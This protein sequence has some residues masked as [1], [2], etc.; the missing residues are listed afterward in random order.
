MSS[1][2][3]QQADL[4]QTET[5]LRES[6][7]GNPPSLRQLRGR[8]GDPLAALVSEAAELQWRARQK[9]ASATHSDPQSL[10]WTT[11]R[12]LAQATPAR[13]ADLKARLLS[14]ER[15]WDLCCGI[16][17]DSL[18]L[19]RN[20]ST[21]NVGEVYSVDR[22]PVLMAMLKENVRL[23]QPVAETRWEAICDD[24]LSQDYQP[25]DGVH[26]DPDRRIDGKR[27]TRPQ[28]Y[29]PAWAEVCQ[30]VDR[31]AAAL[32]KLAPAAELPKSET[33]GLFDC[34]AL[35]LHRAWISLSGSVREQL[36]ICGAALDQ[37][38]EVVGQ[39]LSP[40]QRSAIVLRA[41]G[42]PAVFA[43]ADWSL[44]APRASQ[45]QRWMIDPDAAVRA[46]G[47]TV[48]FADAYQAS[49]LGGPA[50]YLT[51]DQLT[52]A[53]A[54]R[55]NQNGLAI[56]ESVLWSGSSDDRRL[57]KKM[58]SLDVY[59]QRVKTRGVSQ[60]PNQL[61]KR[62]R[63]CGTHPATLWIGKNGKGQYAVLSHCQLSLSPRDQGTQLDPEC[64]IE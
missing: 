24:V 4:Q 37:T 63:E 32:I 49:T 20:A 34:P 31:V 57:R 17:G 22:D 54:G 9:L 35:P 39:P 52:E 1:D 60:D 25:N 56:C 40:G 8:V 12:S 27:T 36:L 53:D 42:D 44:P 18:A 33:N 29:S 51:S 16:G 41:D 30:I 26:I 21:T 13:V 14:C 47:L 11:A 5:L 58:R 46:A 19:L 55:L 7:D 15:V 50:G 10:W 38:S 62:Y 64:S 45:V 59:P 6:F 61:E 3:L 48:A 28:D 23:N 43:A 2:P